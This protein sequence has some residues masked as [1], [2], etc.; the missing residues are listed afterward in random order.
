MKFE[1][2]GMGQNLGDVLTSATLD[3]RL[4]LKIGT[5]EGI[6][7]VHQRYVVPAG[8]S[9]SAFASLALQHCANDANVSLDS[10]DLLLSTSAVPQQAIPTTASFIAH[11]LGLSGISAFDINASCL[12]FVVSLH[13]AVILLHANAYQ[14]IGLVA[15]DVASTGL[16]WQDLHAS[17]IFGDGAVATILQGLQNTP[18]ALPLECLA[19][20]LQVYP[21][22][23][24]FCQ[25]RAG[26]TGR[27]ATV[28]MT[29]SDFYFAM[30]GK[31]VF[32]L[33]MT[34]T[35]RFVSALLAKAG[36]DYSDVDCVVIHQASHLAMK[37]AV[38]RL[39]FAP[40]SVI[41]IYA[42]HGNQVSASIPTA[43]YH[44]YTSGKLRS[45]TKVALLGTAAGF[46]IGGM[47][48]QVL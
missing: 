11:E 22:G 32:K 17:T 23:R 4:G 2:L 31:A 46:A 36:L 12:G 48:L 30:D 3:A 45:G 19:F 14:R 38:A 26:G 28:G 47:I 1:L 5:V 10:L 8:V 42:T 21:E 24:H 25:I 27:N 7:G 35:E 29:D 9:Q 16:N 34:H 18:N 15:S 39:G 44:A 37:H 6:S 40:D 13:Q 41:N 43:L 33:A 20:D